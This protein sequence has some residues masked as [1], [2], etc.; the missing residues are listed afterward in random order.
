[1]KE[2]GCP[3]LNMPRRESF[4]RLETN[5]DISRVYTQEVRNVLLN[6][7][8]ISAELGFVEGDDN[9]NVAYRK[10]STFSQKV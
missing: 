9:G 5:A 2:N 10:R 1:M 7:L 6:P 3:C 8:P 4:A